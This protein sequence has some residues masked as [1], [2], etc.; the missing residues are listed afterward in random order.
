MADIEKVIKGLECCENRHVSCVD[1]PY[2]IYDGTKGHRWCSDEIN[3]DALELLKEQQAEIERLKV[4]IRQTEDSA[5]WRA[6][7]NGR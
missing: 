2:Y 5:R 1:C 6:S 3:R 4:Q 7:L